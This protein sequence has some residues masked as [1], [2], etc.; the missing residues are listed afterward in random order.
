MTRSLFRCGCQ[1]RAACS[2]LNDNVL[3]PG[4]T[5]RR[6]QG[7]GTGHACTAGQIRQHAR[8]NE[9][10]ASARAREAIGRA[11]QTTLPLPAAPWNVN[12]ATEREAG[13][14]GMTW[15]ER[16]NQA[17]PRRPRGARG[18]PPREQPS[19]GTQESSGRNTLSPRR[20]AQ[21]TQQD[22]PSLKLEQKRGT[23]N[24]KVG[25]TNDGWVI[26][27]PRQRPGLERYRLTRAGKSG[28]TCRSTGGSCARPVV[29]AF[30]GEEGRRGVGWVRA[31]AAAGQ[32]E[33]GEGPGVS[34]GR[35]SVHPLRGQG[36]RNAP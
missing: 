18:P 3:E 11:A 19:A 13:A 8:G 28:R 12:S 1:E 5:G 26:P 36:D 35:Y 10:G 31:T 20:Q 21:R 32:R 30:R 27:R 7:D 2:P 29:G 6:P 34:H 9:R 24:P 33:R 23:R 17:A 4:E 22:K 14:I 16:G 15:Q 25:E